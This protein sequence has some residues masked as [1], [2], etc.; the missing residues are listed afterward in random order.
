M[1]ERP[2]TTGFHPIGTAPK[3]E[4][5]LVQYASGAV[6]IARQENTPSGWIWRGDDGETDEARPDANTDPRIGWMNLPHAR[7]L[8]APDHPKTPAGTIRAMLERHLGSDDH[9]RLACDV[10]DDLWQAG[11]KI[12]EREAGD[13]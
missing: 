6:E 9:T 8:G 11:F 2:M 10:V 5:I 12:V 1:T 3:S 13:E 7:Q 4:R